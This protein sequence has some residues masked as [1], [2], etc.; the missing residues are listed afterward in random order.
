M[1]GLLGSEGDCIEGSI[2]AVDVGRVIS[3]CDSS[4]LVS[5]LVA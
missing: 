3:T 4:D 5:A 2:I 1:L